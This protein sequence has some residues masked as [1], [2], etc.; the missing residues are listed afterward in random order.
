MKFFFVSTVFTTFCIS[1][2]TLFSQNRQDSLNTK[3]IK[4]EFNYHFRILDS[5]A[6]TALSDTITCCYSSIYFMET[7]TKINGEAFVTYFGQF[8][9][10]KKDLLK[11]HNWYG[12]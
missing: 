1:W 7:Y 11:W 6:K 3:K 12:K 9:F 4:S 10:T 5:A 2:N 8:Y